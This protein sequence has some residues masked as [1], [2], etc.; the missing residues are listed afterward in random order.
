MKRLGGTQ[1][2]RGA[3]HARG[4]Q[5]AAPATPPCQNPTLWKALQP[6]PLCLP[7]EKPGKQGQE[8][9]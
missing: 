1:L 9:Y 3:G 4:T 6:P 2:S 5:D 8:L 7:G